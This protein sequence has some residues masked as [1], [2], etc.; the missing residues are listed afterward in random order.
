MEHGYSTTVAASSNSRNGNPQ[1]YQALA[2][3]IDRIRRSLDIA[4]IFSTTTRE[5]RQLLNAERVAIFRFNPDWSGEFV[6]E[7]LADGWTPLVQKSQRSIIADSFLQENQGGRY[8]DNKSAIVNDIYRTGFS[9]C[10][11]KMLEKLQAR[12]Y[13]I[14]PILQ[15]ETL[16]GLLA[17]YQNSKPRHWQN[18]EAEFLAQIGAHLG[19]ALQQAEYLKQT[20]EQTAQ[21]AIAAEREKAAQRHRT[22]IGTI[23][24]IRRSLDIDTI[25]ETTTREVLQLLET[26]RTVIYHFNHDWSGQIVAEAI[27]PGWTPLMKDRA[28]IVDTVL[29]ETQGGRYRHNQVTAID[30]IY[31]SGYSPCHVRLLERLEAKACIIVP[32]LQGETLWGLLATYQNSASR[33]WQEYEIDLLAQIGSQLGIALQQAELLKTTQTQADRLSHT[34]KELQQTQTQ[35]IQ[36]EKMAGLGQLV[37]GIAHEINNPVNFIF[38]NLVHVEGYAF[39]LIDLIDTYHKANPI[40]GKEVSKKIDDI[41]LDFV[42]E[43]LPKIIESMRMGSDRIRKIVLSLRTFSR[44]DE[45]ENKAADIHAGLDSTLLILQHRWKS[46]DDRQ[47]V[48]LIKDYGDLP[49][50]DCY[51]APLNQVFMNL[52]TN[53]LDAIEECSWEES[54]SNLPTIWVRTAREGD[55]VQIE[56]ADNGNGIPEA[57]RSRIFDPFFTTKK[58]GKGTGLGLS[59]SYQIIV[60]KHG[61]QLECFSQV[62]RGSQ[63]RISIPIKRSEAG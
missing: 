51:P 18:Y 5:V 57:V 55:R 10:H 37:A 4:T 48:Q 11:L 22:L 9:D 44:L 41:D 39:D 36:S 47:T 45:A 35:L 6:A 33:H 20:R 43:D 3:V 16:W 23:D 34:L 24:R 31:Q 40:P 28:F 1:P 62:G 54:E 53:A 19:I 32:I 61:G 12:A 52:L 7:S 38:G 25:F 27:A 56:I 14:V 60:E 50:V 58:I 30:D 21:L 13:I 17:A 46:A 59:I 15:G 49:L 29:Q 8:R 26:E 42:R 2:K 63:F